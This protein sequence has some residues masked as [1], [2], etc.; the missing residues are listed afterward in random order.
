MPNRTNAATIDLDFCSRVRDFIAGTAPARLGPIEHELLEDEVD[1]HTRAFLGRIH[2]SWM[3]GEYRPGYRRA[4][5]EI[6]RV[7]L[8][9]VKVMLPAVFR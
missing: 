8:L 2:P 5:L 9:R 7:A 4:E 3:G 6:A 1:N